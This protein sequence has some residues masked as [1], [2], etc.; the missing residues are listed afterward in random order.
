[1]SSVTVSGELKWAELAVM[2]FD[3]EIRSDEDLVLLCWFNEE[4][5]DDAYY[6]RYKGAPRVTNAFGF[7]RTAVGGLRSP[8]LTRVVVGVRNHLVLEPITFSIRL[9]QL[10]RV[11]D[12]NFDVNSSLAPCAVRTDELANDDHRDV[13]APARRTEA[14]RQFYTVD[15][16]AYDILQVRLKRTGNLTLGNGESTGEGFAGALYVGEPPTMLT[17]PPAAYETRKVITNTTD[18]VQVFEEYF[19]IDGANKPAGLHT[20]AIVAAAGNPSA[21]L[22]ARSRPPPAGPHSPPAS[23][24]LFTADGTPPHP[25]PSAARRALTTRHSSSSHADNM[26]DFTVGVGGAFMPETDYP[27]MREGRGTFE[28]SIRH[29]RFAGGMID[30]GYSERGGCVAYDQTRTYYLQSS[31][32]G[33]GN[34]YVALSP[35]ADPVSGYNNSGNVSMLRARCG[36]CPWVEAQSNMLSV[37]GVTAIAASPCDLRN[38]SFWTVEVSLAAYVPATLAGLGRTEFA[39]VLELQNATADSGMRIAP[40]SEGGRGYACCGVLKTFLLPNVPPGYS[41]AAQLNVTAGIVRSI[42]LKHDT[43]PDPVGDVSATSA[44]A[45]V[46]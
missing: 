13:T 26:I 5:P 4:C 27:S 1:M 6:A 34:L 10:P 39:I 9:L 15:M 28:L 36:G 24:F 29:R 43:C 11:I 41:L 33:D 8:P 21:V 19:C 2:I 38:A 44:S 45:T 14:C 17:P 12:G 37:G 22:P 35:S 30:G 46:R 16:G 32:P 25:Q 18:D 40:R 7:N 31:G 42:Y 3:G 20:I 23:R